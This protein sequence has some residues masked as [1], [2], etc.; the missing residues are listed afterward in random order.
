ML[1][2]ANKICKCCLDLKPNKN[3]SIVGTRRDGS[4]IRHV[5][6]RVCKSRYDSRKQLEEKLEKY[7]DRYVECE[8]CDHIFARR[9]KTCKHCRRV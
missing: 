8:V 7:P 6:C 1:E 3:F 4:K 2:E 9:L 5:W